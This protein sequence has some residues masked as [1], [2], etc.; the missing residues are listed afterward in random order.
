MIVETTGPSVVTELHR[1]VTLQAEEM[2][3]GVLK[4]TAGP[5][6][7]RARIVLSW[8]EASELVE[9]LYAWQGGVLR[10]WLK[11]EVPL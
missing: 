3:T 11:Q 5:I 4:I 9:L 10:E 2:R 1:N 7:E 8:E 6:G